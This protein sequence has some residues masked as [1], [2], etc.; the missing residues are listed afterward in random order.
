[1]SNLSLG[2][3]HSG[4]ETL[5]FCGPRWPPTKACIYISQ[6]TRLQHQ[7][8]SDLLYRV[9]LH[10]YRENANDIP[11]SNCFGSSCLP[12]WPCT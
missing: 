8:R 5:A 11:L 10:V 9:G 1:M 2:E 6:H 4:D 7:V 12:W 3:Y